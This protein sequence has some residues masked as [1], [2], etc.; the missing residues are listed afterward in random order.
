MRVHHLSCLTFCPVSARLVNGRGSALARGRMECHCLL[1][2]TERHG[3][4]L[5][6]TAIGSE[7]CAA[8]HARL[9][10]L[11]THLMIGRAR[12]PVERTA[13]RQIEALGFRA[14]DVRH[15]VVTHLDLD[16]AGGLPD[17]PHATVHL[18]ADEK[19]AALLR[20]TTPEKSRYRPVHFAHG[21]R[22]QTYDAR[23]ERW[24]GFEVVRALEGLPPEIFLIPLTGHTRG[25]ACV[26][27]EGV[28]GGPLVHCGD[29]Y[30]HR[31]AIDPARGP[32]PAGLRF[33]ER[34]AAVDGRRIAENHA[35]LRALREGGDV[36]L[37][38]AHDP[39][40]YDAMRSPSG[41]FGG[42]KKS[43]VA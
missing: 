28:A 21:P 3:L 9:G 43:L 1:I 37:F 31:G 25:H 19:D 11:F 8:P 33:F 42:E 15:V 5:V 26:A 13:L 4:V 14:S 27:V 24:R 10:A 16:H 38:C 2:G 18:L 6:D 41:D 20:R 17:F 32:I 7:D 34:H 22:W 40:E 36:R 12:P 29:A 35:R 30:F 23:G 39:D